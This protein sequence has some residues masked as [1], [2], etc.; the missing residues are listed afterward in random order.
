MGRSVVAAV[1]MWLI[2][3]S[4]VLK[5]TAISAEPPPSGRPGETSPPAIVAP[6]EV[7]FEKLP[8]GPIHFE[9][10]EHPG[11]GISPRLDYL[12]WRA[13]R[14][15]LDFAI[16]DPN[17]NG[18]PEGPVASTFYDTDH[19][20]RAG[21]TFSL[22]RPEWEFAAYYT[23]F[24]AHGNQ[25]YTAPDG[26]VIYATL[27]APLGP[28]EVTGA[29]AQANVDLDVIDLQIGPRLA[30]A[31]SLLL[32]LWAGVRS[33][34]INMRC[35]ALYTGGDTG[36]FDELLTFTGARSFQETHY[37]GLGLRVGGQGTW[38]IAPYTRLFA[39]S[40][41]SLLSGRFSE[42]LLQDDGGLTLV[43]LAEKWQ[44]VTPVLE[45][46]LGLA[47]EVR[48]DLHLSV[49]YELAHWFGLADSVDLSDDVAV[50]KTSRRQSDLTFEGLF[51]QVAI[52]F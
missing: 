51:V 20:V 9:E 12:L 2:I 1:A 11:N 37:R 32:Q 17:N 5:P 8:E 35:N 33:A 41:V 16:V 36:G 22:P 19:G 28:R 29:F 50:G 24:H 38:K 31:E 34:H 42:S 44:Q 10:I 25:T 40:S 39:R 46:G 49:G 13:R 30:V 26:G 27:L 52:L 14:R 3:G 4:L 47:Y 48:E 43:N 15:G 23:Y 21:F 45:L 18:L 6:A 7:S